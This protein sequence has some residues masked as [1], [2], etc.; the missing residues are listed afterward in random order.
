MS[1]LCFLI[2]TQYNCTYSGVILEFSRL[3]FV[4]N[5]LA[6]S[7]RKSQLI[8]RLFQFVS[9]FTNNF[10]Y[11]NVIKVIIDSLLEAVALIFHSHIIKAI[12]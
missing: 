3:S 6:I 5:G 12:D 4:Y 1:S 11:L 8:M 7:A 9:H 2:Y 10:N